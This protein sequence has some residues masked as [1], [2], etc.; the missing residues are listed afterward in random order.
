MNED[1]ER[2]KFLGNTLQQ[3]PSKRWTMR[4]GYHLLKLEDITIYCIS[5]Q[6]FLMMTNTVADFEFVPYQKLC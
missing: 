6:L 3:L 1:A 2:R 5:V 4:L